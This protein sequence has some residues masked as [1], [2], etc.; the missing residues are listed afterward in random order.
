MQIPGFIPYRSLEA[1][2]NDGSTGTGMK[3]Y[4]IKDFVYHSSSAKII[5]TGK[6]SGGLYTNCIQSRRNY[7]KLDSIN[8]R[9]CSSTEWVLHRIQVLYVGLPGYKSSI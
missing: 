6:D 4:E 8:R 2:T 5:W 1:D 7:R 3:Q 9:K